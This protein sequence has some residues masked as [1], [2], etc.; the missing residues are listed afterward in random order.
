MDA[1]ARPFRF[2]LTTVLWAIAVL[3][4]ALS[5]FGA[6]GLI[7]FLLVLV[8]WGLAYKA[9]SRS[10][11]LDRVGTYI[12]AV[13]LFGL[14]GISSILVEIRPA[15]S[16]TQCIIRLKQIA[17][18]LD[19]YKSVFGNFPPICVADESGKPMHSWRVLILPFIDEHEL[20]EMYNFDEPW[21]G[22]NNL[23]LADQMP[24]TYHC[25]GRDA[26]E[27]GMCHYSA[28]TGPGSV[29]SDD[30][31]A[32]GDDTIMLVETV[33]PV[34]WTKPMDMTADEFLNS[35]SPENVPEHWGHYTDRF[36]G[37]RYDGSLRAATADSRVLTLYDDSK[38]MKALWDVSGTKEEDR[39]DTALNNRTFRTKWGTVV[40]LCLFALFSV[41]PLGQMM[42]KK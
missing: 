38:Y 14:C 34:P 29:F 5:T 27:S 19:S 42:L 2:R 7:P 32:Y 31:G 1:D 6:S 3:A 13:F 30:G 10:E 17:T 40:S 28:L 26:N 20:Y 8:A 41:I 36:L 22:P 18:A 15:F 24:H 12:A 33:E 35:L 23:R 25:F 39:F 16:R 4:S 9:N 21:N 37:D 11:A